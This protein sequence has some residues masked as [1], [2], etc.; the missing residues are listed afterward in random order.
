MSTPIAIRTNSL[1]YQYQ[2]ACILNKLSIEVEKGAIYGFL[3]PNGAG[4]TTTIKLLLGLLKAKKDSIYILG[5]DIATHKRAILSKVGALIETP[6]LYEH[7]TGWD[8]LNFLKIIFQRTDARI[9]EVLHT[10]GLL[11]E[12]HKKVKNYSLGMKQRLGIAIAL[13]NDPEILILDEPNNGLD[14]IGVHEIRILLEEIR[15]QGKTILVSS[16]IIAEIEKTCTHIGIIHHG[17]L[18]FQNRID[19]IK[20]A[21]AQKMRIK[22]NKLLEAL[23]ICALHGIKAN[24]IDKRHIEIVYSGEDTFNSIIHLL[25]KAGVNIFDLERIHTSVE[26]FFIDLVNKKNGSNKASQHADDTF[27][28]RII[29]PRKNELILETH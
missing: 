17:E 25:I 10:V 5:Q 3:G 1:C 14:P 24:S 18:L 7:L 8:N 11:K 19:Q 22:T 27:M 21:S 6:S 23:Q 12:A 20:E 15:Q 13:F 26:D 16:H 4:K 28:K 2:S 29:E 9:E